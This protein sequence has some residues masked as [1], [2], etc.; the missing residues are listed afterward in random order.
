M[1]GERMRHLTVDGLALVLRARPVG[2]GFVAAVDSGDPSEA[3]HRAFAEA[4]GFAPVELYDAL[5][6]YPDAERCLDALETQIL[7]ALARRWGA[8]QPPDHGRRD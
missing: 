5:A 8:N 1:D 2:E 3:G 4:F 6:F 7:T